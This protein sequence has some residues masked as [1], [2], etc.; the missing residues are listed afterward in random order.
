MTSTSPT[1]WRAAMVS[2][3]AS[4]ARKR[5]MSNPARSPARVAQQR[6]IDTGEVVAHAVVERAAKRQEK[7]VEN[8]AIDLRRAVIG[9][10][11]IEAVRRR[12]PR[13]A[14][15]NARRNGRT[16]FAPCRPYRRR[17]QAEA[18]G[19]TDRNCPRSTA[20]GSCR[21]ISAPATRRRRP[22]ANGRRQARCERAQ[23]TAAPRSVSPRR[24]GTACADERLFRRDEP[25]ER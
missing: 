5:G 17:P 10:Q 15:H 22:T 21:T 23:S 19:A 14:R 8:G 24:T 25:R 7:R 18:P 1:V 11:R 2:A 13:S 20:P 3:G 12:Q 4:C 6:R 9:D 16:P